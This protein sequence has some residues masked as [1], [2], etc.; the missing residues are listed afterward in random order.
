MNFFRDL[1]ARFSSKRQEDR[2]AD[3]ERELRVHVEVETEEQQE[4]G[5][6]ALGNPLLIAEQTI[7]SWGWAR[8]DRLLQDVRFAIRLLVRNP[9]FSLLAIACLTLG[10]GANAAVFSWIEG[11]LLRPYPAVAHQEQ[12]LAIAG[13]AR[14]VPGHEGVSWPDFLDLEKSCS[15]LDAFIVDK[16]VGTTLNIGDRAEVV[17]GSLVSANYFDALGVRPVLGRGFQPGEDTGRNAHPVTVISYQLWKNRFKGDANIIGKTQIMNSVPHTII[18]VAPE[19]FY[20]TFIGYAFQFWVPVSM[21]EKFDGG[22]YKLENRD[23]RWIEGFVRLKPGVTRA[24]AQQ[25]VSAAAARL[26]AEFPTVNRGRGIKLLPLWETPF[27]HAGELL[28]ILTI[29]QAVAFLVLLIAC[30]NVGNL[31]LVRSFARR[32]EITVRIA[33]GARRGRL[34]A[35]LLTEGLILSSI[36]AVAGLVV[37]Y[38]CRNALVRVIPLNGAYAFLPGET[39]WRVLAFSACICIVATL[40]AG[41]VPSLQASNIDVAGAL[42]CESSAVSGSSK[43]RL[44]SGLV[45][46]QVALSFILLVGAGL[47]LHSLKS[48]RDA[49]PGF[50]TQNLLIT[51][52]EVSSGYDVQRTSNYQKELLDRIHAVSGVRSAAYGRVPV[53]SY[54]TYSSARIALDG[55]VP[56]AQQ[57]PTAE[58]NE[59]SPAY[60]ATMGLPI[61]SGREFTSSDDKTSAPVAIVNQ[62]MAEKYWKGADPVG[63]RLQVNG[64]WMRVVGVAKTI[65]YQNFME[66]PKP[67]FYVPLLQN[68]A[69]GVSLT[70]RTSRSAGSLALALAHEV[71]SL[72]PE[73]P[74]YDVMTMGEQIDR[75]TS[76]QRIA[77]TLLSVFGGL[78]LLLAAVGLYAVMSY[79]VSQST[80]ELGL[81]VAL[82]ATASNLLRLVISNGMFLCAAGLAVGF[83]GA[84]A[85]SGL[86]VNLLYQVSPRD[87]LAF[88]A[89]F[90]LML[91]V[92]LVACLFPAWRAS[93]IDPIRVLRD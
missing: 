57:Q 49:N 48:V 91:M 21:Q 82:G 3:L 9:A 7:E 33:V 65:K 71:H 10:I 60:F 46:L 31:L 36:A 76:A 22:G 50:P 79:S 4:R 34:V 63:K 80:R 45:L 81:R 2:Q 70:V 37:A 62:L 54:R 28:P 74:I 69:D 25:E 1:I 32:H 83:A 53:F 17:P 67:F 56:P 19:G 89:A 35:Q 93:R 30:A 68:P 78:A 40:L 18:G 41:I 55:Y 92:S 59:V 86:V 39:D 23:A 38:W 43:A 77:V 24:Q 61:V 6:P 12:L 64:K 26:E 20:G 87:P 52:I 58:Y 75:Q 8:L 88:G 73:L 29:A 5:L 90:A 84:L 42:R 44:R 13:T 16:I 85:L 72:D 11:L 15:L 14:G 47:V 66:L 51:T 27:N